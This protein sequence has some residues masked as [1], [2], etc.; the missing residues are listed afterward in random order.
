MSIRRICKVL[1]VA[2]VVLLALGLVDVLAFSVR[3]V[4]A[5]GRTDRFQMTIAGGH[6]F[7][8][9]VMHDGSLWTCA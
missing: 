7:S 9:A 2:V 4:S 8:M 1:A 3:E 5:E 6:D